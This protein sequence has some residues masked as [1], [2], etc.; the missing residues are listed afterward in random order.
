M[1][2][3]SFLVLFRVRFLVPIRV[4]FLVLLCVSLCC[5]DSAPCVDLGAAPDVV[6][7]SLWGCYVLAALCYVVWLIAALRLNL[8]VV[9][10]KAP[11][12]AP[13]F[14]PCGFLCRFLVLCCVCL[15]S[16][17]ALCLVRRVFL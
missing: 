15:F 1:F 6:R 14:A 13:R 3:A 4:W 2:C 9:L 11:C 10:R 16:C 7:S 8:C 5:T 17:V 12:V